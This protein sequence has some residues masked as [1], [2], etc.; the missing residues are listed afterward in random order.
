MREMITCLRL[1]KQ[2]PKILAKVAV[3]IGLEINS[4]NKKENILLAMQLGCSII[5]FL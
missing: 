5:A 1:Q 3:A 4:I 2:I